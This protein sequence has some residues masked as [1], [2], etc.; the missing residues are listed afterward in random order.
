[1]ILLKPKLSL[2]MGERDLWRRFCTSGRTDRKNSIL[3][4]RNVFNCQIS[5]DGPKSDRLVNDVTQYH[6]PWSNRGFSCFKRQFSL[7]LVLRLSEK[8]FHKNYLRVFLWLPWY[9]FPNHSRAIL[10]SACAGGIN[11]IKQSRIKYF[12]QVGEFWT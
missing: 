7:F 12:F 1:L 6:I 9:L 11:G 3:W 2:M 5:R 8:H 10:P 4:E